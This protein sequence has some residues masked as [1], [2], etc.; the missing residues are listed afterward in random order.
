MITRVACGV[1]APDRDDG[2]RAGGGGRPHHFAARQS[3]ALDFRRGRVGACRRRGGRHHAALRLGA[4]S[5]TGAGESGAV[6]ISYGPTGYQD[7]GPYT[8][9]HGHTRI[10]TFTYLFDAGPGATLSLSVWADDTAMVY[11]DNH[12]VPL[13]STHDWGQS[14]CEVFPISCRPAVN[15]GVTYSGFLSAGPHTLE[16]DLFQVGTSTD[17]TFNPFGL[18]VEGSITTVPEPASLLLLGAGLVGLART[19]RKRGR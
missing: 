6:W 8:P 18:M 1:A 12:S 19:W 11:L 4:E 16:V 2:A 17:T 10:G 13:W 7:A 9:Y 14:T 3:V 15:G 5:R